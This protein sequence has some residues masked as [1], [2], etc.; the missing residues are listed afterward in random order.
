MRYKKTLDQ[1]NVQL[2]QF[3]LDTKFFCK[4]LIDS[5]KMSDSSKFCNNL[6]HEIKDYYNL[7]DIMIIDSLKM[8]DG[9]NS[10]RVRSTIIEYTKNHLEELQKELDNHK[11]AKAVIQHDD[12]TTMLYIYL[13]FKWRMKVME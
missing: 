13:K 7:E 1:K 9:E 2:I 5:L 3:Y 10:T 6:I 11:L 4:G 12:S 8:T